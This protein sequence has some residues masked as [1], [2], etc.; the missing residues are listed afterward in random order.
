[1]KPRVHEFSFDYVAAS[2]NQPMRRKRQI[3]FNRTTAQAP[4]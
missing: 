1:L 3:E 4:R 2:R